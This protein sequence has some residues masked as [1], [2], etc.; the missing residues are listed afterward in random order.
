MHRKRAPIETNQSRLVRARPRHAGGV[1]SSVSALA[2]PIIVDG[3]IGDWF[4]TT[5]VTSPGAHP[6]SNT[7]HVARNAAQAGEF[8]WRDAVLDQRIITATGTLTEEIDLRNFRVTA[9]ATNLYLFLH[10]EAAP[11]VNGP[12][13]VEFQVGIDDGTGTNTALV[14]GDATTPISTT[15]AAP[16]RYLVQTRFQT[17]TLSGG[18]GTTSTIAPRVYSNPATFSTTGTAGV[19]RRIGIDTAEL[20]I[21]GARLAARLGRTASGCALPS[22]PCIATAPCRSAPTAC[23]PAG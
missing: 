6:N 23:P 21:P 22:P 7:G 14:D 8:N 12:N 16:W 19:L 1:A 20:R 18:G 13:A 17:G 10:V 11:A 3:A 5:P 2:Q 9:D 4:P 15:V